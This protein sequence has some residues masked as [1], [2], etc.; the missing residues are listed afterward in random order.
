MTWPIGYFKNR[1]TTLCKYD[2]S[3]LVNIVFVSRS[4]LTQNGDD[5]I[6]PRIFNRTAIC[7]VDMP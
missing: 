7:A 2:S 6:L 4:A 5:T 1:H 3:S